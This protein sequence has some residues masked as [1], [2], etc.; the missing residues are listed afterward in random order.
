[1]LAG[2]SL[3]SDTRPENVHWILA[4]GRGIALLLVTLMKLEM[5]D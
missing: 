1:M 4:V 5:C 2:F 3:A